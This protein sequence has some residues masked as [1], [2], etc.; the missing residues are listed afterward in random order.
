MWWSEARTVLA[1]GALAALLL[2][3]LSACGFEPVYKPGGRLETALARV[4]VEPLSG[5]TGQAVRNAILDE[6]GASDRVRDPLW[7]LSVT[8]SDTRERV[9]IQADETA[10]R[11]NVTVSSDWVL[12]AAGPEGQVVDRGTVRRTV[13]YNVVNDQYATTIAERD[14]ARQAGA[15]VGQAIRTRLLL[16]V[17]RAA[18][19]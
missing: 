3:A 1:R 8:V 13:A 12:R 17:R 14:A 15:A 9:A 10:A 16:A 2:L 19:Q 7:R 18:G 4:S 5:R 11:V 6:I